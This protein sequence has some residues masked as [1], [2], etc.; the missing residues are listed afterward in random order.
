MRFARWPAR[1][2]SPPIPGR[3]GGWQGM[4]TSF[5]PGRGQ[6][7]GGADPSV[8]EHPAGRLRRNGGPAR[9]RVAEPEADWRFPAVGAGHRTLRRACRRGSGARLCAHHG[10]PDEFIHRFFCLAWVSWWRS[11]SRSLPPSGFWPL[12]TRS[13]PTRRAGCR[14]L[15]FSNARDCS[16]FWPRSPCSWPGW[17]PRSNWEAPR[18]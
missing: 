4:E 13:S 12:P 9:G 8:P 18:R 2:R 1:A 11:P 17:S 15:P 3:P 10:H 16:P 14:R 7:A 6:T 5:H